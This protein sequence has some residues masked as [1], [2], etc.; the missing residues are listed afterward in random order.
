MQML[1][2]GGERGSLI[3]EIRAL[4][5]GAQKAMREIQAGP[6]IGMRERGD[7]ARKPAHRGGALSWP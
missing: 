7:L 2:E 1:G 6:D 5:R 4:G 3:D